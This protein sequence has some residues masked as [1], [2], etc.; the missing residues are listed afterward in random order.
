MEFDETNIIT[1]H[2]RL[3]RSSSLRGG[4]HISKGVAG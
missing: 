1:T 2:N 3:V 4:H